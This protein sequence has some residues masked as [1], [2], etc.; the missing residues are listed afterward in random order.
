MIVFSGIIAACMVWP[1]IRAAQRN[2]AGRF[3][4]W[5]AGVLFWGVVFAGSTIQ[6]HDARTAQRIAQANY[7]YERGVQVEALERTDDAYANAVLAHRRLSALEEDGRGYRRP[8]GRRNR[9]VSDEERLL[10][11]HIYSI[12]KRKLDTLRSAASA[13]NAL[14]WLT[15]PDGNRRT[16]D[17]L[18]S[19]NAQRVANINNAMEESEQVTRAQDAEEGR[20]RR[21]GYAPP[22]RSAPRTGNWWLDGMQDRYD[23][24]NS[25]WTGSGRSPWY[26]S[27]ERQLE[28]LA[29]RYEELTGDPLPQAALDG[30]LDPNDLLE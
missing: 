14:R 18:S 3:F 2:A 7:E 26:R 24:R 5:L 29:A 16:L 27:A 11:E 21:G 12:E 23:Q 17:L 19:E 20:N 13:V 9:R 8:E 10:M 1:M 22:T 30:E 28:E 6:W 15:D 4:F 25:R